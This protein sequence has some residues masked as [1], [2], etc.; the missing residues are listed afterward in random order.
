MKFTEIPAKIMKQASRWREAADAVSGR[1]KAVFFF[2]PLA[3]LLPARAVC[4]EIT[5]SGLSVAA[6]ERKWGRLK[7]GPP[8]A[9]GPMSS[10]ERLIVRAPGGSI[11]KP[12]ETA[13]LDAPGPETGGGPPDPE[14]LARAVKD[15]AAAGKR[16][17]PVVLII[18]RSWAVTACLEL[19][20]TAREN[21]ARVV[22][23]ELD[24]YT[25]FSSADAY[26]D[27]RV[28]ETRP[29][30]KILLAAARAGKIDP[31]LGALRKEGLDVAAVAV[32]LEAVGSLFPGKAKDPGA[33]YVR[34]GLS[35]YE[36]ATIVGGNVTRTFSGAIE[37][38]DIGPL[39]DDIRDC[40]RALPERPA[41]PRLV[42]DAGAV[43]V[44]EWSNSLPLWPEH[45]DSL[46][47]GRPQEARKI[48]LAALGAL[49][50]FLG[51]GPGPLDLASRGRHTAEA[52]VIATAV[53]AA[54]VAALGTLLLV[55]PLQLE[56]K[57]I[58]ELD[59][60]LNLRKEEVR[61]A[62]AVR[63]E[64]EAVES[65]IARI[66]D[67]RHSRP[68][69]VAIMKE[70]NSLLP[71]NAWLVRLHITD[72]AVEIEG[73]AG[74]ASEVLQKLEESNYLKKIEYASPTFRDS[75]LNADRFALKAD[76]AVAVSGK[77]AHEN[78]GR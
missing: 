60:R 19:P 49:S 8:Q 72:S 78:A 63:R 43:L 38:G 75:R 34:A 42:L 9:R 29:K 54:I 4:A 50:G 28:I 27:F 15:F 31:Y 44:R 13:V 73:Y 61:K 12:P 65:E 59:S 76:L 37:K 46:R 51:G 70:L 32:G 21:L 64:K 57:R 33:I 3:R 22:S 26:Y 68:M 58:D 40:M 24:R 6:A 67:F 71:K 16:R 56:S 18:P 20:R 5:D 45:A 55:S 2:S 52:S 23:Y 77:A 47:A 62:E 1:I 41:G 74:S 36:G 10:S 66:N 11:G 69:A 7:F 53:L 30:L 48:S 35:G 25:P 14:T 17:F 39:A